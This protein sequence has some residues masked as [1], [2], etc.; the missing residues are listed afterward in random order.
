MITRKL[1]AALAAG[2]TAVIKPPPE[3][4]FSAL[5]L[6]EV[7]LYPVPTRAINNTGLQLG[8]RA[9]IPDGVVNIVP[10]FKYVSEV[11]KEMCQ[12][13]IVKK[14]SFTGSTKV[15]KLL[16]GLSSTTLKKYG[17]STSPDNLKCDIDL[18]SGYRLKLAGMRLLLCLTMQTL[19]RLLRV[20]FP[21]LVMLDCLVLISSCSCSDMQV[22]RKRSDM[23]LCK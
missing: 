18:T 20:C 16:Y 3:T 12:N 2:C 1:G 23:R 5:A 10:T 14:V 13:K 15:A 19:M 9:G 22:P 6:A 8:R 4:P 21:A 17:N 11:G 7:C